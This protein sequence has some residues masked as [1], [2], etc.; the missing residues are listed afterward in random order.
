MSKYVLS[1][2]ACVVLMGTVF[3]QSPKSMD[4]TPKAKP[5][6]EKVTQKFLKMSFDRESINLGKVKR[7][8][9]RNFDYIFTNT[10]TETIEVDIASGCDCSTIDYPVVPI[11]P[12][13]KGKIHV[14]FDSGKKEESETVDV[15]LYLKNIDPK[16][17][18][19][20]FKIL[21]FTFELIQ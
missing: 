17:G 6:T 4:Y 9:I 8:E 10:G 18:H 7:G 3:S 2:F 15:D 13:E 21:N 5:K 14:K 1:L 16:T 19:R 12:G 20:V 11:K